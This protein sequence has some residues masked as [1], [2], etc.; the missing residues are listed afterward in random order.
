MNEGF[1]AKVTEPARSMGRRKGVIFT[2]GFLNRW[3]KLPY[4]EDEG[5]T[6]YKMSLVPEQ[7]LHLNRG[8]I[9]VELP[10]CIPN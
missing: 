8:Y 9:T 2:F 1:L 5:E 10:F 7:K 3:V 4:E 6:G